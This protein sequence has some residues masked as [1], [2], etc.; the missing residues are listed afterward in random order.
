MNLKVL[1]T[2]LLIGVTEYFLAVDLAVGVECSATICL[3]DKVTKQYL[4][5]CKTSLCAFV[6]NL[7]IEVANVVCTGQNAYPPVTL[8]NHIS[9]FFC[10]R[11]TCML[12]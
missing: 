11:Y 5:G 10:K 6:K 12:L 4:L 8:K 9:M 2:F 3:Q 7:F 1:C